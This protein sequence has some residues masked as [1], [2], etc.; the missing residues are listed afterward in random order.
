MTKPEDGGE[1]AFSR[2]AVEAVRTDQGLALIAR[3]KLGPRGV[4]QVSTPGG[5]LAVGIS[6]G[7]PFAV[8]NVCR[9]QFAKLGNGRVTGDGCLQCPWHRAQ[10]NVE[11]GEMVRG[12]QGRIF[13]IPP[14][15]RVV[16][17]A[18]NA[19]FKLKSHPVEE[20]DGMIYLS[21][22]ES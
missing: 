14:Y 7:L 10:F 3:S 15:S 22:A 1:T 12:P 21:E 9:H 17:G 20:R 8:S 5:T 16:Q 13:G 18:S 11:S 6:N 2:P 19:A 4:A